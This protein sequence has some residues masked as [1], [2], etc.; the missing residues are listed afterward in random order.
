MAAAFFY[1]ALSQVDLS[2]VFSYLKQ[3]TLLPL[4]LAGLASALVIGANT[5]LFKLLLPDTAKISLGRLFEVVAVFSMAVNLL[6]FGGGQA[7]LVYLLGHRERA[8]KTATLSILTLEQIADGFSKIILFLIVAL[9]APLPTWL[10]GGMQGLILVVVGLYI[11][12]F[13]IAF[14]HPKYAKR[15]NHEGSGWWNQLKKFFANWAGH[16][17]ALRSFRKTLGMILLAVLMKF[18]QVISVYFVQMSLGVDLGFFNAVF[19]V[20]A[21][22]LATTLPLT[23]GRLGL[24]EAAALLTYQYL[25]LSADKAMALGLLIHAAQLLPYVV[26]GYLSSLKLGLRRG[27]LGARMTPH[28]S[29]GHACG[30]GGT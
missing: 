23:P 1:L 11:F 13:I 29:A 17:H 20:V 24:V 16:L 27:E 8:G 19:V 3:A 5:L 22:S 4:L 10:K 9:L 6:P 12:L 30:P 26:V 28:P 14:L 25:G 15:L 21:I 7:L 2:L 18:L